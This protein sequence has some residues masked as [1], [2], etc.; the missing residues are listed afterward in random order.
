[1]ATSSS[2]TAPKPKRAKVLTHRPKPCS[3]ERTTAV[4]DTEK[5]EIVEYAEVIPLASET[6]SIVAVEASVDP[7]EETGAQSSEA[8]E[9]PKLLSPPT[10]MGLSKLTTSRTTTPRKR[11]MASV[12]DAVL[13]STKM[14]TP[15]TTEAFEDKIE[16]LREVAATSDSP[17]HVE[18][19]PSGTKPVE[20]AK[21]CLPKKTTPPLP[22]ASSQG[23]L[24]YIVRHASGKQLSE[25]QIV[26]VHHYAKDLKYSLGSLVYGGNDEDDF[27]NC[28]PDSKEINVCREMMDN[29]GYLKLELGL[30]AMMKDQLANNL[31]YNSL[32]V[33]IFYFCIY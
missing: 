9:H 7:V 2:F 14:P 6:I 28:L 24:E 15:V 4:P 26:E 3:L 5:M 29:M 31:A 11:R 27:L 1:M 8:E 33:C 10:T 17:I 19:G 21:E 32:K 20:L 22:E 12:L 30:S 25:E 23:D 13:K 18:A 16:D